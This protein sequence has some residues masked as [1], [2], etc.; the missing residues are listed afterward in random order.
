MHIHDYMYIHTQ[1]RTLFLART[2]AHR[3]ACRC[4]LPEK[5]CSSSHRT[6]TTRARCA[7][8]AIIPIIITPTTTTP[9]ATDVATI[10]CTPTAAAIGA[11]TTNSSS[12]SCWLGNYCTHCS[13]T[14]A[15]SAAR[16]RR[17]NAA[18]ANV[19]DAATNTTATDSA[20][21]TSSR[22]W[23]RHNPH[24]CPTVRPNRHP[25]A[26]STAYSAATNA[27]IVTPNTSTTGSASSIPWPLAGQ[28]MWAAA[29]RWQGQ[30]GPWWQ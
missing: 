26:V 18:A 28:N 12:Q 15:V 27:T 16:S 5:V 11:I 2:S 1:I 25:W 10:D 17:C 23:R 19:T 20:T 24:T 4:K 9:T 22:C 3:A 21:D 8:H 7:R 14:T 30:D 6:C 13:N 29:R